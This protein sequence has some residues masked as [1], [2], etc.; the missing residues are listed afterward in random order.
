MACCTDR[1]RGAKALE[2]RLGVKKPAD[3]VEAPDTMV[4]ESAAALPQSTE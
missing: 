4:I 2:E 1:E 3:D